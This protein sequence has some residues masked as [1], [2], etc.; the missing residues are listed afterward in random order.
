MDDSVIS[1][2]EALA[3]L[4]LEP[5]ERERLKH[6]LDRILAFVGQLQQLDTTGVEPLVYLTEHPLP[7]RPDQVGEHLPREQALE[8]APDHDGQF[9]RVPK[10]I[11]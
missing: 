4:R 10:V 9:F 1:K 11:G 5:A 7:P 2:L 3:R 6:D 8:N